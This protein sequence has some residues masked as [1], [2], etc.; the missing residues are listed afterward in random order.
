MP[1]SR[2]CI[3]CFESRSEPIF[4]KPVG[5]GSNMRRREFIGLVGGVV[6]WPVTAAAQSPKRVGVL[7]SNYSPEDREGLAS[8]KAL[9]DTLNELGWKDGNNLQIDTR[10]DRG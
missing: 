6:A 2:H 7:M 3:N 9:A 5:L 8:A 10:W 4:S 1:L